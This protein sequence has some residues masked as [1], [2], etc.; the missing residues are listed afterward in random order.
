MSGLLIGVIRFIW[1]YSYTA[2]PCQLEHLDERPSVVRFHF[3]YFSVLL[4]FISAIVTIVVSLLTQP[5]PEKYV[6]FKS[7]LFNE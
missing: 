2:M 3:L 6:S 1:E 5:I 4:F 7:F